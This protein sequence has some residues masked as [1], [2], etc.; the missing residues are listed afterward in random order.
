MTILTKT[1]DLQKEKLIGIPVNVTAPS[2][3]TVGLIFCEFLNRKKTQKWK[4][5]I[6]QTAYLLSIYFTFFLMI[7]IK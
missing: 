2:E 7:E 3:T 1:S 4:H 5:L 6:F